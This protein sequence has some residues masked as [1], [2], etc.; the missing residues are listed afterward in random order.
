MS[1]RIKYAKLRL[2]KPNDAPAE[3]SAHGVGEGAPAPIDE[4]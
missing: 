2:T 1:K 3:T 4:G